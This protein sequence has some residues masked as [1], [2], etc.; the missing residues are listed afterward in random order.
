MLAYAARALSKL[1]TKV[2][3]HQAIAALHN[4]NPLGL[5]GAASFDGGVSFIWW[6]SLDLGW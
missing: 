4:G 3:S 1:S 5:S 2:G 6:S